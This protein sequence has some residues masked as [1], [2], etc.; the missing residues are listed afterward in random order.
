MLGWLH[1]QGNQCLRSRRKAAS[2]FRGVGQRKS[3]DV[4][5]ES[6]TSGR[7][8]TILLGGSSGCPES[9][10][11]GKHQDAA[12]L[13]VGSH[14]DGVL[15]LDFDPTSYVHVRRGGAGTLILPVGEDNLP[16]DWQEDLDIIEMVTLP[17]ST[18]IALRVVNEAAN[19]YFDETSTYAALEYALADSNDAL[20]YEPLLQPQQ[21]KTYR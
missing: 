10:T 3:A 7:A 6:R 13:G 20:E 2:L 15:R 18:Y 21:K 5:E 11:S 1:R 9:N 17:L 12:Q 8:A 16:D 4:T 14:P 19:Q